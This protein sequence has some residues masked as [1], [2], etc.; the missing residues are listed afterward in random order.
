MEELILM[1]SH[2]KPS[3][4]N[5]LQDIRP[6]F[7][8][9]IYLRFELGNGRAGLGFIKPMSNVDNPHGISPF[10]IGGKGM[11]IDNLYSFPSF[12]MFCQ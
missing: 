4:H 5:H 1:T 10:V 7:S 12:R 3:G 9:L 2:F 8:K 11:E 6:Y